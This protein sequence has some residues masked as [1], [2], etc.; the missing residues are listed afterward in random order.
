MAKLIVGIFT[1]SEEHM[2]E[3]SRLFANK[4]ETPYVLTFNYNQKLQDNK[5]LLG[6]IVIRS[7]SDYPD[8]EIMRWLEH[9]FRN[10]WN[11]QQSTIGN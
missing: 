2:K 9:G 10:L 1:I 4:D 6:D 11:N 8:E 5:V 3:L 7:P